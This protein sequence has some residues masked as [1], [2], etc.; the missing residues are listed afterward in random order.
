MLEAIINF[1]RKLFGLGGT[2]AAASIAASAASSAAPRNT[3]HTGD[4]SKHVKGLENVQGAENIRVVDG[5]VERRV[6]GAALI[7]DEDD[8]E[9]I[10]VSE[11]NME[12]PAAQFQ[13]D[14]GPLSGPDDLDKFLFHETDI[15]MAMQGDADDAERK[16][17]EFGYAHMGQFFRVRAT[18]LKHKGTPGGPNLDDYVFDSNDVMRAAMGGAHLRQAAQS[19]AAL[20]ADPAL[21]AP[22][23]GVDLDTYALLAASSASGMAQ[24]EFNKMLGEHGLDQAKWQEVNAIWSD[25]MAKDTSHTITTAYGKAFGMAGAGKHGAAG[26]AGAAAMGTTNA[27]AGEAPVSFERYCEIQGAQTAWSNSGQDVNAM[28]KQVFD[29]TAVDWST[30]SMWWMQKMQSDPSLWNKHSE[31]CEKYEKQ[32]GGNAMAGADDD[33]SF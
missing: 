4:I 2:D 12:M 16:A 27:A 22:V 19:E 25:R 30:M 9:R 28:L 32:Y 21:L 20:A 11:I 5:Q 23:D 10:W 24:D 14:F 6:D 3:P 13:D 17:Q 15:N 7:V 1:F 31:L 18:M 29:M 8:G 33:L 26:Q